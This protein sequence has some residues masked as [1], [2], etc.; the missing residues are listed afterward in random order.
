MFLFLAANNLLLHM[1]A[2]FGEA[3]CVTNKNDWVERGG[4]AV[5]DSI[6]AREEALAHAFP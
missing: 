1:F 3:V 6:E 2:V 4:A 5:D